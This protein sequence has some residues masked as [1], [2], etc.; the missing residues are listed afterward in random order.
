MGLTRCKTKRNSPKQ[1]MGMKRKL[2]DVSPEGVPNEEE[3]EEA[4]QEAMAYQRG[5]PS[6]INPIARPAD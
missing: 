2:C 4:E 1:I 3:N 5:V 6:P